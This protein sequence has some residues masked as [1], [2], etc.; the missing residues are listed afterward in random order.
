MRAYAYLLLLTALR[1]M[2]PAQPMVIM[3]LGHDEALW[4]EIS[5]VR[6]SLCGG[7]PFECMASTSERDKV[8]YRRIVRNDASYMYCGQA[9]CWRYDAGW[10]PWRICGQQGVHDAD[11][12]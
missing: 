12:E 7:R 6:I 10:E 1:A 3:A 11:G 2:R 9:I 4:C 5:R 8:M